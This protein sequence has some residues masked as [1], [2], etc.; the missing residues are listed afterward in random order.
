MSELS[1]SKAFSINQKD[2]L[3]PLKASLQSFG[4]GHASTRA[5]RFAHSPV[6]LGPY[7]PA[8]LP[9]ATWAQGQCLTRAVLPG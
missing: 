3:A 5:H 6:T 2:I 8:A 7:H 9:T 1:F 4:T